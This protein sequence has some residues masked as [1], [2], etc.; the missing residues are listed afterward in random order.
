V[1]NG[2]ALL[3]GRNCYDVCF[4][5]QFGSHDGTDSYERVLGFSG[6]DALYVLKQFS[7]MQRSIV[8]TIAPSYK[9]GTSSRQGKLL[10]YFDPVVNPLEQCA[11]GSSIVCKDDRLVMACLPACASVPGLSRPVSDGS[12][13]RHALKGSA[14]TRL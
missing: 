13:R 14:S 8:L 2:R 4:S 11:T 7:T 10:C 1:S 6:V 9:K 12:S 3:R 5:R